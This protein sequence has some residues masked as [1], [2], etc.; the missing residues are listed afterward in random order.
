L[1]VK[2]IYV[3]VWPTFCIRTNCTTTDTGGPVDV[4]HNTI[5]V[6]KLNDI[7]LFCEPMLLHEQVDSSLLSS[8]RYDRATL[9]EWTERFGFERSAKEV[10]TDADLKASEALKQVATNFKTP[11]KSSQKSSDE[12][13]QEMLDMV[14]TEEIYKRKLTSSGDMEKLKNSDLSFLTDIIQGRN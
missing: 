7:S 14:P 10:M 11:L 13:I 1:N 5:C 12:R 2:E 4:T 6:I 3:L 8:W 9:C